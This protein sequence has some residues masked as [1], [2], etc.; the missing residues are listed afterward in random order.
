MHI[1]LWIGNGDSVGVEGLFDFFIEAP[2]GLPVFIGG[3]LDAEAHDY[4]AVGKFIYEDD[5]V[6][7]GLG[8]GVFL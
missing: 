4:G 8:S 6:L 1:H 7:V 3:D 2:F 5:H